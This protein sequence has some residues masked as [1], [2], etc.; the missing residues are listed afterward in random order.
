NG[1]N[2]KE[3]N[4]TH[5][6]KEDIRN[7]LNIANEKIIIGQI[8]R[9]TLGKGHYELIK[10]A[11]IIN[12]NHSDNVIFLIVG[13]SSKNEQHIEIEIKKLA[14]ECKVKNIL[15]PGYRSDIAR[16]LAGIDILAFPSHEESFGITLLEAMAME[17]PVVATGNAGITDIIPNNE[18]GLLVPPKNF[19]ALAERLLELIDNPDLRKNLAAN[20]RKRIVENFDIEKLTLELIKQYEE[21]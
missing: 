1:I 8:G 17:V 7:E 18:Y 4:K 9:I 19:N 20:G 15:F 11:E 2:I 21:S 3:Y 6:N 14:A 12:K 13:S 16:I 5:F 10:A